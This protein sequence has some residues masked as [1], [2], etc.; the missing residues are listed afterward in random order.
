MLVSLAIGARELAGLSVTLPDTSTSTVVDTSFPTQRLPGKLHDKFSARDDPSAVVRGDQLAVLTDDITNLALSRTRS[1][2]EDKIPEASREK[3]LTV[4]ETKR[5]V[6]T[7]VK[8]RRAAKPVTHR[9]TELA[10]GVFIMPLINRFWLYMRDVATSP[11]NFNTGIFRGGAAGSATLLDPMV[12][13]RFLG[14]L[15]V[16]LEAGKRSPHFLAVLAPEALEVVL[17]IRGIDANNQAV[18]TSMLQLTLVVLEGSY[19]LDGGRTLAREFSKT[20]WQI[21]DWAEDQWKQYEGQN[22]GSVGRAAAGVLL[23]LD[24]VVTKTI[25]YI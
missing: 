13:T 2:A 12:L 25:G 23:R 9:F 6:E 18:Q 22:V 21:K 5:K 19:E 16:L 1:A 11:Q 4:R 3:L 14:T 15:T 24:D 17:A 8:A 7:T 10:V 20:V